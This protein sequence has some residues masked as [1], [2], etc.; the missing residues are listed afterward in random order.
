METLNNDVFFQ[1]FVE[2]LAE[3]Q[4]LLIN[5]NKKNLVIRYDLWEHVK[6]MKAEE[7]QRQNTENQFFVSPLKEEMRI[8]S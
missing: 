2:E 1:Q 3:K 7:K 6:E 4:V 8:A 5:N